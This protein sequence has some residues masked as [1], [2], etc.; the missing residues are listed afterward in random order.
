MRSH[1]GVEEEVGRRVREVARE[2]GVSP[3]SVLPWRVQEI[4][5]RLVGLGRL[6]AGLVASKLKLGTRIHP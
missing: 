6:D 3:A 5:I 2:L 1:L 4:G